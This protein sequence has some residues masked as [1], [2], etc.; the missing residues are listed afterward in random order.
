MSE[1]AW[2]EESGSRDWSQSWQEMRAKWRA[3][4]RPM[5]G[6]L[7]AV[8]TRQLAEMLHAGVPLVRALDVL[9][10]QERRPAARQ[11]TE[12][13]ALEIRGGGTLADGLA[14][15]ADVFSA[16]Y[17]NMV[18]AGE[19]GGALAAVLDR[20]ARFLENGERVRGK[21]KAAMVYPATIVVVA[22][23]IVA[24]LMVW[25][26][27]RFQA[28][29]AEQLRGQSLPWL[30]QWVL[31]CAQMIGAHWAWGLGLGAP[32]AFCVWRWCGTSAGRARCDAWLLRVPL[33]GELWLKTSIARFARTAGTLLASGVPI[34][35]ALEIA[36]D[37]SGNAPIAD[38]ISQSVGRVRAGEPLSRTLGDS[39]LFPAMPVSLIAVGE[40]TG[41]MPAMLTRVADIYDEEVERAVV[42]LTALIEPAMIVLMAVI[43]GGI[44]IALFLPIVRIIQV[45]SGG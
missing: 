14:R 38:A 2:S 43:V 25:V 7:L 41:A 1:D 16:L 19:A 4:L 28:L 31:G 8:W 40:E 26:V 18:R 6:Q 39:P 42:G 13:L 45:M 44:V 20:L 3:G 34:L 9:A 12:S 30:T 11:L 33:L 17:V 27:P 15:R 22:G 35:Q 5:R 36:R 21:V 10:R 24:A 37:T 32:A 29:F 23:G